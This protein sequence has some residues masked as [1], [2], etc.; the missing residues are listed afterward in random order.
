[1]CYV[2][3]A[4]ESCTDGDVRLAGGRNESEGRV[5]VCYNNV[6]GTVCDDIWD[7]RD[8][9]AV[10]R[11]LGY[12]GDNETYIIMI[13]FF[14]TCISIGGEAVCC[15]E[16]GEGSGPIL[17]DEVS[18]DSSTDNL[19][20]CNHNG[21]GNNDCEHFEDAGVICYSKHNMHASLLFKCQ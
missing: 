21:L 18:C 4:E 10:C 14:F 6:W 11:Q 15:A 7:N 13:W 1:M 12:T 8:A 9:S 2:F 3:P 20:L 16:F 19:L 5:E 17:L